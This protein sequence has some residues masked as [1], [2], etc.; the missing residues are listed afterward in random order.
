MLHTN[1]C[2]Y[3]Q[4]AVEH[5]LP[6]RPRPLSFGHSSLHTPFHTCTTTHCISPLLSTCYSSAFLMTLHSCLSFPPHHC[7]RSPNCLSLPNNAKPL[8]FTE[9]ILCGRYFTCK[10]A[11]GPHNSSI[12]RSVTIYTKDEES[13]VQRRNVTSLREG[14][15]MQGQL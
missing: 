7:P 13:E 1:G 11:L 6:W 10:T 8:P 2:R 9:Y 12:S 14:A 4:P 5:F 3:K 15:E